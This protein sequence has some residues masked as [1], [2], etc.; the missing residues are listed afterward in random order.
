M[1]KKHMKQPIPVKQK[2][3]VQQPQ[4]QQNQIPPNSLNLND[5]KQLVIFFEQ[6]AQQKRLNDIELQGAAPYITRIV[7]F[8]NQAEATRVQNEATKASNEI[9]KEQGPIAE[10]EEELLDLSGKK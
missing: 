7:T 1:P 4:T 5:L 8:L 2:P 10:L 6:L 9:R 3:Q